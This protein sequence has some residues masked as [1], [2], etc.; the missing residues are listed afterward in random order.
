M[1][2]KLL[3]GIGLLVLGVLGLILPIMPGIPFLIAGAALLGAE[4]PLIRPF[5]QRLDKWRG[6]SKDNDKIETNSK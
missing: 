1:K 6:E 5:K 4:H 3:G 2:F